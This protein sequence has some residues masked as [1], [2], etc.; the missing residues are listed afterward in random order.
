MY[1]QSSSVCFCSFFCL[2]CLFFHSICVWWS[3]VVSQCEKY[4]D[5]RQLKQLT[6][7]KK[8]FLS[9]FT[10]W[11]QSCRDTEGH[12][13]GHLHGQ[14]C[15]CWPK[16]WSFPDTVAAISS[17]GG[18]KEDEPAQTSRE[19]PEERKGQEVTNKPQRNLVPEVCSVEQ[20]WLLWHISAVKLIWIL[21]S[22]FKKKNLKSNLT[23]CLELH[24]LLWECIS[25]FRANVS[26]VIYFK[27]ICLCLLHLL[28]LEWLN[29]TTWATVDTSEF[30]VHS[31]VK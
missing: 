25:S 3:D 27:F 1:S 17:P 24:Y 22:I 20:L 12:Q 4:Y 9:T 10:K 6:K 23:D 5:R 30:F 2:F 7:E 21:Y 28:C 19:P 16:L 11:P 8:N 18:L 15:L 13:S 26:T 29:I 14:A 31:L